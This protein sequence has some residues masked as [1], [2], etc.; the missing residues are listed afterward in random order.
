MLVTSAHGALEAR[1]ARVPLR[2][3]LGHPRDR[4]AEWLGRR[5]VARLAAGAARL[6]EP[7]AGKDAEVLRDG[8]ARDGERGGQ[9][10]RGDVAARG[11][12]LEDLAASGVAQG[13]EDVGGA[14]GR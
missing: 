5:G 14:D 12:R 1:Q 6:D 11:N 10:G 4:V 9:L 8:L 3:E 7:G 13:S 2:A